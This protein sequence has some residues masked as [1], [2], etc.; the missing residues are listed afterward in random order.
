MNKIIDGMK[1]A[2]AVSKG[3]TVEGAVT[4]SVFHFQGGR[5]M[6]RESGKM[7]PKDGGC[8]CGNFIRWCD[9]TAHIEGIV[10]AELAALNKR[11]MMEKG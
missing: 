10:R 3:E 9:V 4:E 1:E 5:L 8:E 6:L 2:L 11:F 7:F